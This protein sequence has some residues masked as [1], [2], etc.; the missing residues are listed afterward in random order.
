M[1]DQIMLQA[2]D[3]SIANVIKKFD[4]MSIEKEQP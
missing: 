3:V 4:V 2:L 1:S